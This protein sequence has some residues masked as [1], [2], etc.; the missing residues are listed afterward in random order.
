[1]TSLGVMKT[2]E[3][4]SG[5]LAWPGG[6]YR[7]MCSCG[8]PECDMTIDFHYE[9]GLFQTHFYEKMHWPYW[10]ADNWFQKMWLRIKAASKILF[11]GYMDMESDTTV[12]DPAILQGLIDVLEESKIKMKEYEEDLAKNWINILADKEAAKPKE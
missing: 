1:M 10:K 9:D 7:I 8:S 2:R 6:S 12:T 11:T 3:W 4:R 5:N